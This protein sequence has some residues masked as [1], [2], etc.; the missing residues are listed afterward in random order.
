[1]TEGRLTAHL[2]L[3]QLCC[4]L[5]LEEDLVSVRGHDFDVEGVV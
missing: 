3:V 2:Q 4:L 1:M 5:D